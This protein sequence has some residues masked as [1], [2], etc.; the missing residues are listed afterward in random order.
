[1]GIVVFVETVWRI[2]VFGEILGEIVVFVDSVWM[3]SF[4]NL[5]DDYYSLVG[6]FMGLSNLVR[7]Y[8]DRKCISKLGDLDLF[9]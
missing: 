3:I 2:V 4:L 7:P 5:S 9:Q 1:M 8:R 6:L